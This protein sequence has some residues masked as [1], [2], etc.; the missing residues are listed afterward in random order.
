[1]PFA[2][3]HFRIDG[4]A[5]SLQSIWVHHQADPHPGG[6]RYSLRIPTSDAE[7][8]LAE[9][10]IGW[11]DLDSRGIRFHQLVRDIAG[12][13]YAAERFTYV[14]NTARVSVGQDWAEITGICSPFV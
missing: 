4:V 1:M 9:H 14:L 11:S 12:P 2:E 10:D 13:D 6:H 3:A 7:A 8:W 5:T